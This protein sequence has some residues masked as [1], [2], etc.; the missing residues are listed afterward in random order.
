MFFY[1]YQCCIRKNGIKHDIPN[2]PFDGE[3][4]ATVS[5]P[6][7]GDKDPDTPGPSTGQ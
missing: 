7:Q 2:Y 1:N 5:G 6:T 4:D 3:E